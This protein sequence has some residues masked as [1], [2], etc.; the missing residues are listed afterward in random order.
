M[1]RPV[2]P[3]AFLEYERSRFSLTVSFIVRRSIGLADV[4]SVSAVSPAF[5]IWRHHE[6]IE[7]F[8]ADGYRD[9]L[10]CQD[11]ETLFGESELTDLAERR[12]NALVEQYEEQLDGMEMAELYGNDEWEEIRAAKIE[13]LIEARQEALG[14]DSE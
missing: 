1:R 4:S 8:D 13:E 9:E 5:Y 2:Q 3:A 10:E 12:M 11:D 6:Q 7:D 14:Q